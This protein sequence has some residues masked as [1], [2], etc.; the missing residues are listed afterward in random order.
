MSSFLYLK[1]LSQDSKHNNHLQKQH[2]K[3]KKEK[4]RKKKWKRK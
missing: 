2:L 3:L 1:K 4:K